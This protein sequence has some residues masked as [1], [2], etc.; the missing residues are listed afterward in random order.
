[1]G[2]SPKLQDD[3]RS[4]FEN[5]FSAIPSDNFLTEKDK[6]FCITEIEATGNF[7]INYTAL[8]GRKYIRGGTGTRIYFHPIVCQNTPTFSG[9]SRLSGYFVR[10]PKC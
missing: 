1:M 2:I 4:Q 10:L 3:L 6:Y 9:V 8:N 5:Q 7:T